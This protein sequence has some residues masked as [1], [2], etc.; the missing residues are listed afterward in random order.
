[1]AFE[2]EN[3]SQLSYDEVKN[4]FEQK[5]TSPILIDVRELEEYEEGHIPGIPLIPMS[6]IV[7]L[8]D[9]F[10]KDE[11]YVLV[12][13]SGRRSHEVSKFFK[14]NGI[15]NVHNYA[16][17][18]LGWEAEKTPGHEWVVEKVNEIYNRSDSK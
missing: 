5:K 10:K 2:K 11:E 18:M 12:C 1:M 17:G 8:V 7:D 6:E 13:R 4:I 3:V 16:D 14:S 9:E 15:D